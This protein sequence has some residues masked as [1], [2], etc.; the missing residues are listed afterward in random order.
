MQ[1][2]CPQCNFSKD[3]PNEKIPPNAQIVTCPRCKARFP[4]PLRE[5][6]GTLYP[7]EKEVAERPETPAPLRVPYS[8]PPEEPGRDQP[9]Q[10]DIPWESASGRGMFASVVSTILGVIFSPTRFY[11]TMNPEGKASFPLAFAMITGGV[12][13]LLSI[14]WEYLFV[15]GLLSQMQE[16][17][18][19][20]I[21]TGTIVISAIFLP[22]LVTI[23]LYFSS[24]VTHLGLIILRGNTLPFKATFKVMAYAYAPQLF[25]IIPG[26][27]SL[28]GAVWM[29]VVATIGLSTVHTISKTKAFLSLFLVYFIAAVTGIA[30]ISLLALLFG[31]GTAV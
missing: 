27:G 9:E 7:K 19:A 13:W 26:L 31:E 22:L 10:T 17:W 1:I 3:V 28:I 20:W 16:P 30:A 11:T 21:G 4:L 29:V 24:A 14:F 5:A 8:V 23:S 18:I 12:G 15:S 2:T 25:G 6:A